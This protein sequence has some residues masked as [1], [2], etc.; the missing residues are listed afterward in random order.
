MGFPGG[1]R[2]CGH[3]LRASEETGPCPGILRGHNSAVRRPKSPDLCSEG[4]LGLIP[5]PEGSEGTQSA[6]RAGK[7]TFTFHEGPR[8]P[9]PAEG[10]G[11][12][13]TCSVR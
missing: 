5:K 10:E 7:E 11:S 8:G 3:A 4:M 9:S 13:E 2:E 1:L 12:D 6:L